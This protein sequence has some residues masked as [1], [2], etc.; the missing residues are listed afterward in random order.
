M[1]YLIFGL[2]FFA[3]LIINSA[4]SF[5]ASALEELQSQWTTQLL[6]EDLKL[7]ASTQIRAV[8]K[9]IKN[10]KFYDTVE[11][12][13][14]TWQDA[15]RVGN[16]RLFISGPKG[17]LSNRSAN[18][19]CLFVT[20][21]F[22][23]GRNSIKLIGAIQN[24][25]L[26]GY[27]YPATMAG[28]QKNPLQFIQFLR[29][30]PGQIAVALKWISQQAWLNPN[31]LYAMGV[32]LGGLFLPASLHIAQEMDVQVSKTI[33]GFSGAHLAPVLNQVLISQI[34]DER[35]RREIV[36]AA[37]NL[38]ALHDP[39]LHVPFLKGSFLT[40]RADQDQIFPRESSAT[41]ESLLPQPTWNRVV[42]GPHIDEKQL[43]VIAQTREIVKS[44]L[45]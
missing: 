18:Y 31:N 27:E 2:T 6:M 25:V 11:L 23:T 32:S 9:T 24:T 35:A 19:P 8:E 7:S 5:G 36:H 42:R 20:A 30:T 29:Q 15:E 14:Q 10:E 37:S 16:V 22:F 34:P 26:V 17:F 33:F 44:W 43:D 4:N 1:Q 12:T 39:K 45:E 41:L 38:T 13:L 40:I 28:I 3:C 21:G